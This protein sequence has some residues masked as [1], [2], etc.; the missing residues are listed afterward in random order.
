MYCF[1][2]TENDV[3]NCLEFVWLLLPLCYHITQTYHVKTHRFTKLCCISDSQCYH[4]QLLHSLLHQTLTSAPWPAPLI[5]SIQ[6]LCQLSKLL[7]HVLRTFLNRVLKCHPPFNPPVTVL[8]NTLFNLHFHT[9]NKTLLSS[10][11]G[12]TAVLICCVTS[13]LS[14]ECVF[15]QCV[16][17]WC[18]WGL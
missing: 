2:L 14:L 12:G 8:W 13:N 4:G 16:Q 15:Q 9:Y 17:I 6:A 5:Y 3:W 1:N 7:A 18:Q 10:R 11:R